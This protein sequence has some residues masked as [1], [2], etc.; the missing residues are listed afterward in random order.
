MRALVTGVAGFVG[1]TLADALVAAGHT[2][3]GVDCFSPYY[4]PNLKRRNLQRLAA[5]SGFELVEGDLRAMEIGPLVHDVDVIFHEAAQPGVRRSWSTGF[6]DY[7]SNNVLATQRLLEAVKEAGSARVVYASS[8][9][10]YGNA[11]HY[12]TRET[13]LPRPHSPYGVTKL[14]GEHLCGLYAENWGV[15]AVMLRYFTVYGPRQ[16]PDMAI[17][18]LLLAGLTGSSFSVYGDGS[19]RR[20]LTFV[21][22]IVEANLRAAEAELPSGV[23]I[24]IA[25]D[26]SVSLNELIHAAS[27]AIGRPIEA[28]KGSAQPGDVRAT[29]GA[30]DRARDLLGWSPTTSVRAGLTAE[31]RWLGELLAAGSP[32]DAP[33]GS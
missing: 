6:A 13:D 27:E 33:R 4:D 5:G 16:R 11:P 25:G 8:S 19:Q 21:D 29:G 22:D 15:S 32:V 9:S 23:V 3:R 14:A 24:N 31:A 12:P 28:V 26:T 30:I 7:D 1:S 2:V 20:D 10:V 18:R 17:H